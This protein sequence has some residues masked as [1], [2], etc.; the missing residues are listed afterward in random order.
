NGREVLDCWLLKIKLECERDALAIAENGNLKQAR[1]GISRFPH[2]ADRVRTPT[3]PRRIAAERRA[4]KL[5]RSSLARPVWHLQ[6]RDGIHFAGR[7]FKRDLM[8]GAAQPLCL[9]TREADR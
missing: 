3:C 8:V 2:V 1:R 6:Q 9:P 5:Q 7:R 4:E